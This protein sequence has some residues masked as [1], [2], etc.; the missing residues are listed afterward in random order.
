MVPK[1]QSLIE[2]T[3]NSEIVTP[4]DSEDSPEE[5]DSELESHGILTFLAWPLGGFFL[6]AT[7]RYWKFT[8]KISH[9][10]HNV[11]GVIVTLITLIS[12]M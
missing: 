10:A 1:D 5:R 11:L 7:S 2:D 3:E 6:L 4:D 12:S 8:W 9:I